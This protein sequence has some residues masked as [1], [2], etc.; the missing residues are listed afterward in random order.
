MILN[1]TIFYQ[2]T[3]LDC[4]AFYSLKS[5]V[6]EKTRSFSELGRD[7]NLLITLT[8]FGKK[9]GFSKKTKLEFI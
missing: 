6:F 1:L 5:S 3:V 9:L 2:Q 4:E 8:L 7:G